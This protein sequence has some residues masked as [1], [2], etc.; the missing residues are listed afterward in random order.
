MPSTSLTS[1][2]RLDAR[3]AQALVEGTEGDPFSALGPHAVSDGQIIRAFVPGAKGVEVVRRTDN[4]RLAQLER[5][6]AEGL[7]EAYVADTASYL[8]RIEW[9]TGVQE[10]EDPYSFGLLLGDMDLYL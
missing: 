1:S 7:F 2:W 4:A 9:S 5:S 6:Q 10:T 3:R 8:L